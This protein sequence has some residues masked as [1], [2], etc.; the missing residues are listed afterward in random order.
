VDRSPEVGVVVQIG[1]PMHHGHPVRREPDADLDRVTS[2]GD[3][4]LIRRERVLRLRR[5]VPRWR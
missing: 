5:R 1:P 4:R 3:G 2:L